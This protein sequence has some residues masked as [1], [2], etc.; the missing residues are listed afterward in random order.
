MTRKP[1]EKVAPAEL[2]DTSPAVQ[3]LAISDHGVN[4]QVTNFDWYR[5]KELAAVRGVSVSDIARAAMSELIESSEHLDYL[6]EA[7]TATLEFE[8]AKDEGRRT[9]LAFRN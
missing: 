1:R 2:S 9:Y 3:E 6:N 5:A 4:V 7:V 8:A